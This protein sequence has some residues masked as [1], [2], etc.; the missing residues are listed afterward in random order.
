[1]I[2]WFILNQYIMMAN[3]AIIH[4]YFQRYA[5]IKYQKTSNY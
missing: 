2:Y 1:M 4:E 5:H 3:T